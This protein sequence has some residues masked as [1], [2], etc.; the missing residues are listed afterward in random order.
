MIWTHDHIAYLLFV[1]VVA[2]VLGYMAGERNKNDA[3]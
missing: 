2:F 3:G 1:A